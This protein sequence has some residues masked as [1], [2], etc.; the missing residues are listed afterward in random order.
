MLSDVSKAFKKSVKIAENPFPDENVLKLKM[1]KEKEYTPFL[2]NNSKNKQ[3]WRISS[4]TWAFA[5]QLFWEIWDKT[6]K[7]I[8]KIT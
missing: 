5:K 6:W 7:N 2:V 3:F 1:S 4:K 8:G